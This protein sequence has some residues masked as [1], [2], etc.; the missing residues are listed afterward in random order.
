[1]TT[2]Y[3]LNEGDAGIILKIKGRGQFRQRL[4]EMGFVVGKKVEVI[5]KAPLRDPI[6][7]KI[8]GYHISLRNSEAQLIEV[9]KGNK[10]AEFRSDNGVLVSEDENGSWL[11]KTKQIQVALVGNPNS[12]K[13]TLFNFA[14]GSKEK[15]GNYAGVTVDS[16]EAAYKQSGYT[17]SI[18]DLPGTYSIKSYSPEE[19]YLRNYIFDNKPDI[20]VNIV[21]ASNLER[22]L[23]LTSQLI[24]MGVQIVIALN[25]Y[26]ELEKKGDI[27]DHVSLGKLL[28]VP[29][30]PT[31]SSK[32]KGIKE[33]FDKIIEVYEVRDP[34]VRHI[35]INYGTEIENSICAIQSRIKIEEN[36]AFTNIISA[37]YLAIELL[38]NDKEFSKSITR[39]INSSE[40]IEIGR[41]EYSRLEKMYSE[42]VETVITDLRYG[43]ISGALKETLKI[44]RVERLRKTKMIDNYLTNKYLGIPIFAIFM[45]LT[46][47]TTFKLGGYPKYWMELGFGKLSGLISDNLAPGI[48]RDF[49]VEAIIGG[50]GGVIVFLPN[51]I[52]LFLFISFMEDTGYMARAVFIMDKVM[53]KIGLH[54][55]SFIPLFM[56]FGCNVPAIMATRI[57][58]SRRDRLITMLITPFMSCSARLP[59]YILFISAFFPRNQASVLFLL[60]ILGALF[61]I[62]SALFL[63]KVFFKSEEIPFVMELPPYRVPTI[64]SI[65]KHVRFRTSQY[66]RKI[67]G[68]ILL[69][70]IIVWI[71]S[72][73]PRSSTNSRDYSNEISTVEKSEMSS[74]KKAESVT[75]LISEKKSEEHSRSFMG[76]IGKL[77]EPVMKPLGFDWHLSVSILSGLAAKEVVVST[78]GVIFQADNDT[79]GKSLVEKI[80]TQKDSKGKTVFTPL[81]AFSFMLF[82]LTYFPCVGVVSAIR[83]ESGSWKW[84]AFTVFYT[85]GIAWLLSF[86]VFQIGRLFV[87]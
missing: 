51:I 40:I 7:Y 53:H 11:E 3:D 5:K 64:R 75:S 76:K 47:F 83:R 57:I 60:Y 49:L 81:I 32:G 4:S 72:N 14:S 43:F 55:K 45:W 50:V 39:C 66:F 63:K 37:R 33:L 27:L 59:V 21:D 67:G 23:Y 22:N 70:A 79:G 62:L 56:G 52:I 69:A 78:L 77:I 36:R 86:T 20:V 46:F 2:L 44:N 12:G 80:Q 58:E 38:E 73:F 8:M 17:F 31:V 10:T 84:A 1:M 15:V 24:D 30:I 54:G 25:M 28:G 74:D 9:D 34:L 48:V 18:V 29:V 82:I 71:L 26:D 16:K 35:H 61:A 65:F 42:P 68:V 6:E 19:I 85:T 41:K 13:T 87:C